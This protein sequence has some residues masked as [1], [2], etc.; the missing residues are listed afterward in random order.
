MG[1]LQDEDEIVSSL[2]SGEEIM[3]RGLLVL[4]IKLQLLDDVT[5]FEQAKQDLLGNE[6]GGELGHLC[7]KK[8]IGTHSAVRPHEPCLR[9]TWCLRET[10][11]ILNKPSERK[12]HP[13]M[14]LLSSACLEHQRPPSVAM[15][16]FHVTLLLFKHNYRSNCWI[17]ENTVNSSSQDIFYPLRYSL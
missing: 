15:I 5:V 8:M 1:Y 13:F 17:M 9:G 3:L 7:K 11:G 14:P 16:S 6:G 2:V 10:G 12:H 4:I